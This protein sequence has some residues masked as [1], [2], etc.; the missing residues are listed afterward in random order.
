MSVTQDKKQGGI[1]QSES[2]PLLSRILVPIV[3]AKD[4]AQGRKLARYRCRIFSASQAEHKAR[5]RT[6]DLS[7]RDVPMW[8]DVRKG[9]I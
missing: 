9:D 8:G 3:M 4:S 2:S 1:W 5:S 7:Q 6:R